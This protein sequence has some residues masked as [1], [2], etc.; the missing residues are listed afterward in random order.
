MTVTS[1]A[2][3]VRAI[4]YELNMNYTEK[5]RVLGAWQLAYIAT[6]LPCGAMND[7]L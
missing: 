5:G 4:T 3:L 1:L 2:P 6:A 7:R